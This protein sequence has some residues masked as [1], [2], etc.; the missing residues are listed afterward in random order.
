MRIQKKRTG[1]RSEELSPRET[2]S[3]LIV[4]VKIVQNARHTFVW[5]PNSVSCFLK[6]IYTA[7]D[8]Q[9]QNWKLQCNHPRHKNLECKEVGQETMCYV[10]RRFYKDNNLVNQNVRLS[11]L[12]EVKHPKRHRE[13]VSAPT[14]KP[15]RF[16][17]VYKIATKTNQ[18]QV[19]K[20][21]FETLLELSH[22]RIL[23]VAKRINNGEE[24]RENRGGN[25][26]KDKL[27][28]KKKSILSFI[29]KFK[30]RESHYN[31]QKSQRL[32]LPSELTIS[33]M[34]TIYN[35]TVDESLQ[36]NTPY[37]VSIDRRRQIIDDLF[38]NFGDYGQKDPTAL[39]VA[40]FTA[41]K[42]L[43][44]AAR[45]IK[46]GLAITGKRILLLWT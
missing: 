20:K 17:I 22:R 44:T 12:I 7:R 18:Y 46:I 15:H 40:P 13:R 11:H 28:H 6:Y 31:R 3:A 37:E 26:W 38:P 4:L 10:K 9:L 25:Q 30:A 39:D 32:Y 45:N 23:W 19:C 5:K 34:C 2:N 27:L 24:I 41:E 29:G 1:I 33:K 36:Y 8:M 35:S 21:F 42:E 16:Q 43:K 14:R